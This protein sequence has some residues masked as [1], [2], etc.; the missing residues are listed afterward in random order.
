M[1]SWFTVGEDLKDLG[2]FLFGTLFGWAI[3]G[4]TAVTALFFGK[5]IFGTDWDEFDRQQK[6]LEDEEIRR[7]I[8]HVH[9]HYD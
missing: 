3:T 8:K 7:G 1:P 9:H 6:R 2:K 5:M 4:I